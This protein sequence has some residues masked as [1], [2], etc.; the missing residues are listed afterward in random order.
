MCVNLPNSLPLCCAKDG[1]VRI[2]NAPFASAVRSPIGQMQ[3]HTT[4][5]IYRRGSQRKRRKIPQL[6]CVVLA[7][8]A[9][10]RQP[11]GQRL[12]KCSLVS[13]AQHHFFTRMRRGK[14]SHTSLII[15]KKIVTTQPPPKLITY[16]YQIMSDNRIHA[17]SAKP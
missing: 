13:R 15:P 12:A 11:S 14:R 2:A 16:S 9:P 17:R 1:S 3:E 5:K 7:R 4:A 8:E 6:G 10:V